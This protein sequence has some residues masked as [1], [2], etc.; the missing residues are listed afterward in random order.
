MRVHFT[1]HHTVLFYP[2]WGPVSIRPH[3]RNGLGF[4]AEAGTQFT[5]LDGMEGW[6]ILESALAGSW[7]QAAGVRS[8]SATTLPPAAALYILL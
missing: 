1:Q 8:K 3:E 2:A 4:P 6:V 5:Y 7:T